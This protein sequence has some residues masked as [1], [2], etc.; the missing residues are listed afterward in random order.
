MVTLWL[1]RHGTAVT[2]FSGV[3]LVAIG[4][5]VATGRLSGLEL[6]Q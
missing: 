4:C 6:L 1:A 5:L 2:R 3:A